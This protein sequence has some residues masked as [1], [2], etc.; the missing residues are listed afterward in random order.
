[1]RSDSRD[2]PRQIR[3]RTAP[4]LRCMR[5]AI[6]GTAM[7]HSLWRLTASCQSPGSSANAAS[8]RCT[9]SAPI[10]A[11]LGDSATSPAT[12]PLASA[13]RSRSLAGVR[14]SAPTKR[15]LSTSLRCAF[16]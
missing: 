14:C 2:R 12:T 3:L 8:M 10:A 7:P 11:W 1:M 13:S 16:R 4:S 6:S 9:S 5:T 15:A